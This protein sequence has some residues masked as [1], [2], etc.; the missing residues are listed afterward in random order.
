[1]TSPGQDTMPMS[2]SA[3][4]RVSS[5]V[6]TIGSPHRG[7]VTSVHGEIDLTT[8]TEFARIVSDATKLAADNDADETHLDLG[9][10]RFIDVTGVAVLVAAA[11]ERA[12]GAI[13]I[14]QPHPILIRILDLVWGPVAGLRLEP[15][16]SETDGT[17]SEAFHMDRASA[18]AERTVNR[19]P[20]LP[21]PANFGLEPQSRAAPTTTGGDRF[22]VQ[23]AYRR[24]GAAVYGLIHEMCGPAD[25]EELTT[26]VFV[27]LKDTPDLLECDPAI[28]RA[29]LLS[30][31]HRRAV[32]FLRTDPRRQ[33]RSTAVSA[34]DAERALLLRVGGPSRRLLRRLPLLERQAVVLAYYGGHTCAQVADL[35]GRSERDVASYLRIGLTRL[36]AFAA[37]RAGSA[38]AIDTGQE[39]R[40]EA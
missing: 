14:H 28:L 32:G 26:Q 23:G 25:G 20:Q 29:H 30:S 2:S 3:P 12:P 4:T 38:V 33:G 11:A 6:T 24:H 37:P 16:C 39:R 19:G 40:R 27:S 31:A 36:G 10:V 18:A 1:M 8:R 9:D 35:L 21:T 5:R 22:T 15:P 17:T 34:A 13:V 7:A